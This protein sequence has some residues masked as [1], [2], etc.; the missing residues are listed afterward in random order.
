MDLKIVVFLKYREHI[1]FKSASLPSPLLCQL[2]ERKANFNHS[3]RCRSRFT[4][5]P[6]E[7]NHQSRRR[8]AGSVRLGILFKIR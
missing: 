6:G 2:W 4:L 3:Q 5:Q 1:G 7:R 8:E